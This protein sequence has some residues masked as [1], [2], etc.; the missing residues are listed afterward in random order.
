[1]F[2]IDHSTAAAS[3]PTPGAAGT[4]GYFT[5]GNPGTGTAATVVTGDWANMVQEELMAIITSAGVTPSKSSLNQ[6][7]SAIPIICKGRLLSTARKVFTDYFRIAPG[8]TSWTAVTG[9]SQAITN[10]AGNARVRARVRISSHLVAS[11]NATYFRLL[12]NGGEHTNVV[13]DYCGID[14]VTANNLTQVAV[15]EGDINLAQNVSYT[16]SV[17][18]KNSATGSSQDCRI[19]A[20]EDSP[21]AADADISSVLQLDLYSR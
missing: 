12:V 16:F 4:Q 9:F 7:L 11:P 6:L 17:E 3:L 10:S 21:S 13:A 2:R 8:D 1:M 19:N 18:A 14:G 5:E 15:L 20:S